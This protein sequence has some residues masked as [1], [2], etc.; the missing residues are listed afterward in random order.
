MSR[1]H[2]SMEQLSRYIEG[3]LSP[4]EAQEVSR[5]LERCG[6]CREQMESLRRML[7]TLGRLP[8][9]APSAG[10]LARLD[11]RIA[12]RRTLWHRLAE[13][14]SLGFL[15]LPARAAALAVV[16][17]VGVGVFWYS[18]QPSTPW[19]SSE[20]HRLAKEQRLPAAS[21]PQ[22]LSSAPERG[23]ALEQDIDEWQE[24]GARKQWF[25]D[26]A[27]D[28]V[29]PAVPAREPSKAA[30]LAED[31]ARFD[32]P[33]PA[34]EPLDRLMREERKAPV[35][36]ELLASGVGRPAAPPVIEDLNALGD[37]ASKEKAAATLGLG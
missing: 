19:R 7:A 29:A 34:R 27:S 12:S 36:E 37:V 2:F 25:A 17:L 35:P 11:E 20:V 10:F 16:L 33:M 9:L 28:A 24:R 5:H 18:G 13:G 6:R 14:L 30:V 15:P 8:D 1:S 22:P 21:S 26:E 23:V 4:P 31:E 3:E 32:Q